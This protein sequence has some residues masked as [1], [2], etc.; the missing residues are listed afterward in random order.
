MGAFGNDTPFTSATAAPDQY[1]YGGS[2]PAGFGV[3]DN[4]LL[5]NAATGQTY[6][7]NKVMGVAGNTRDSLGRVINSGDPNSWQSQNFDL[8]ANNVDSLSAGNNLPFQEAAYQ[9]AMLQNPNTMTSDPTKYMFGGDPQLAQRMA[10]Q[11]TMQSGALAGRQAPQ[12]QTGATNMIMGGA[13]NA[14]NQSNATNL[15]SAGVATQQLGAATGAGY[16]GQIRNAQGLE[17]LAGKIGQGPSAAELAMNRSNEQGLAGQA[18]LAASARGGNTGLAMRNAAA[19]AA[20]LNAA[21]TQAVGIQRAQEQATINAQKMQALG[22]AN[23][24]FGAAAGTQTGAL[25]GA[26]GTL[27]GVTGAQL[28]A[29]NTQANIGQTYA[30]LAKA[31]AQAQLQQTGANDQAMLSSQQL[32]NQ[33]MAQQLQAA[34]QGENNRTQNAAN[35][36]TNQY[37]NRDKSGEGTITGSGGG[38][39]A[40]G[41]G[42]SAAGTVGSMLSDIKEKKNIKAAPDGVSDAFRVAGAAGD[43]IRGAQVVYPG[44]NEPAAAV[45]ARAPMAMTIAPQYTP[46]TDLAP[47]IYDPWA[48]N[49][50]LQ[51]SPLRAGPVKSSLQPLDNN[52][53]T[54]YTP[55]STTP[56]AQAGLATQNPYTT[57][58]DVRRKKDIHD[59]QTAV[60][61]V[62]EQDTIRPDIINPYRKG[63]PTAAYGTTVADP[64]ANAPQRPDYAYGV[65]P[66]Q[67]VAGGRDTA[68]AI[69]QPMVVYPNTSNSSEFPDA[70]GYAY[71]YKV[72]SE[73]GASPGTHY[74]PMAQDLEKTPAG[75]SVVGTKN[76]KKFVDTGRLTMLNT[77]EVS[78]QRKELDALQ[79]QVAQLKNTAVPYPTTYGFGG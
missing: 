19:N 32:A 31:Q 35:I 62:F 60:D 14:L 79:D 1:Y 7:Y 40:L 10:E 76:G 28:G 71:Q 64:W 58:S 6:D 17:D 39:K 20:G 57:E 27:S 56:S 48:P 33:Y 61:Q 69:R 55:V 15:A 74:G 30:D 72:P 78:K 29:A 2:N 46:R 43:Y 73:V 4:G 67:V 63:V 36:I 25:Q 68:S 41:A 59:G 12:I 34:A 18:A 24:G 9:R 22:A 75:A 70:P 13:G 47:G 45:P 16:Q 77:S 53:G 8:I 51:A 42:L 37:A 54:A 11:L 65:T 23:Q 52:L 66:H 38:D 50:S 3:G 49:N 5:K 44:Q 26:A 21:N